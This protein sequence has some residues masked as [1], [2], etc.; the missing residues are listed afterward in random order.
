MLI[1]VSERYEIALFEL[2]LILNSPPLSIAKILEA[3]SI[4]KG[5]SYML[6]FNGCSDQ[7]VWKIEVE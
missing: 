3:S 5:V 1:V 7:M 4:L 6:P 2:C